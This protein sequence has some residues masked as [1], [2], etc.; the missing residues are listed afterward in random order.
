MKRI[1]E[2]ILFTFLLTAYT[3]ANAKISFCDV[4][5]ASDDTQKKEDGKKKDGKKKTGA[6][7]EEEEEEP[8]CD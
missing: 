8:D 6:E 7:G 1:F 3:Q 4:L 2:I 5:A